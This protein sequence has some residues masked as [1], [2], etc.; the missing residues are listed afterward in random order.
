MIHTEPSA[1]VTG[2]L[3]SHFGILILLFLQNSSDTTVIVLPVS[4]K[5]LT[6]IF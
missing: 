1:R 2:L 5:A 4:I 3:K 6:G